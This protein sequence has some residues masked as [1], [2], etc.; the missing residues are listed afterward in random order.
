MVPQLSLP[1]T[2]GLLRES[3]FGGQDFRP[4]G[5]SGCGGAPPGSLAAVGASVPPS[6]RSWRSRP[7]RCYRIEAYADSLNCLT[8]LVSF[9]TGS[10]AAS[11]SRSLRVPL[12]GSTRNMV[13]TVP[14]VV[15][16]DRRTKTSPPLTV[17]A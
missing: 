7:P 8:T 5:I 1:P 17:I 6:S 12:P 14:E 3:P 11:V 16:P 4:T 9:P 13:E 2:S 15:L 10:E